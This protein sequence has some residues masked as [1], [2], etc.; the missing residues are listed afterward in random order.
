MSEKNIINECEGRILEGRQIK[1]CEVNGFGIR[2]EFF[3]N[4]VFEYD[5][6]D[7]GYSSW[8]FEQTIGGVVNNIT[9]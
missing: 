4:S 6:S 3:D 7:S 8:V 1:N 2:I 5:A 9:V